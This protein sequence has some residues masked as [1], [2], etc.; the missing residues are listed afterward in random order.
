MGTVLRRVHTAR[1]RS[2]ISRSEQSGGGGERVAELDVRRRR[3][4]LRMTCLHSANASSF[5]RLKRTEHHRCAAHFALPKPRFSGGPLIY[6]VRELKFSRSP[7]QLRECIG[8]CREL[9][10]IRPPK[11]LQVLQLPLQAGELFQMLHSQ[12]RP[13][14]L[15]RYQ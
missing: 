13:F 4:S 2:S 15:C 14:G 5:Q 8:L 10:R 7:Q 9:L 3:R 6:L 1:F 12:Q 11:S